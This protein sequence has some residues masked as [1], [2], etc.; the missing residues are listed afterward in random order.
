MASRRWRVVRRGGAGR[1]APGGDCGHVD[2]APGGAPARPVD[3]AP[4]ALPTAR[5]FDHMTTVL[6]HA[7]N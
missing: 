4:W 2:D 6:Y 7:S 1:A 5:T 3:N